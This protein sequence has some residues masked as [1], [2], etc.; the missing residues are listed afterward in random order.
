MEDVIVNN[1]VIATP[2]GWLNVI[3]DDTAVLTIAFDVDPDSVQHPNSVTAQCCLQLAEYFA[4]ERTQFSVPLSAQGTAFQHRVWQALQALDYGATCSY[5]D[6]AYAIENPK[7]VRAVG[8]A[9]GKNPIPIIVP[10]HR[11]IGSSGKLTG[12]AGGLDKKVWLL[13]HEKQVAM[14]SA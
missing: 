1:Q 10:C 13:D 6:I 2:I 4:G 8:A 12:Y 5:A 14:R 11:V 9:N 3:A 7:A